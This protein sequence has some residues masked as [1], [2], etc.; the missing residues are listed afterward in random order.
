MI[1]QQPFSLVLASSSPRRKELLSWLEVPFTIEKPLV[2]EVSDFTDPAKIVEDLSV[3]KGK[4]VYDLYWQ[5]N[6]INENYN[7]MIVASDTLVAIDGEVLGKPKDDEEAKEMLM[8]LS[9]KTHEVL[10]GIYLGFYNQRTKAYQQETQVCS[11]LVEFAPIPKDL[12]QLYVHSGDPLDKAG[13]YGIQGQALSFIKGI[14]GSY[15]NVVGFPLYEF[16]NLL[17]K[18]LG[19]EESD[20]GEWRKA[21][22]RN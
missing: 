8:R 2:D 14:Q 21:F 16:L 6:K 17:K 4:W 15:S 12:L 10:T 19:Y 5:Q 22:G 18:T 1:W 7:P 13:A 3:L 20:Q 9:G 11:T